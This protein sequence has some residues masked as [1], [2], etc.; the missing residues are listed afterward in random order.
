MR[1]C[2][3]AL[4]L[5]LQ[6]ACA[7]SPGP[8][9]LRGPYLQQATHAQVVVCWQS[10]AAGTGV[11]AWGT[12]PDRLDRM[13]V[14]DR[15]GTEHQIRLTGLPSGTRIHYAWGFEG[16]LRSDPSQYY[17]VA[18]PPGADVPVRFWVLGDSGTGGAA[19]QA[20]FAAMLR[21]APEVGFLV[22]VGDIAYERG[23]AAELSR[24]FFAIYAPLLRHTPVWPA[25]ANH[26]IPSNDVAAGTGAFFDAFVLPA[27]G[28]AG[29]EPSGTEAYYA[30]D[31]GP[32][33][34][35]V[36]DTAHDPLTPE[37]PMLA[38]LE[39]DLAA[40]E[41]RWT[42]A[43]FHHPPYSKGTHDSDREARMVRVREHVVP[44]LER[45]GV[46]LVLSGHSHGYERTALLAGAW[47]TPSVRGNH[48]LDD[49]P[50]YEKSPGPLGGTIYMVAGHGGADTGGSMDH[51]LVV[52]SST[53]HG[54]VLIEIEGEELR[55]RN[56]RADGRPGDSFT[57]VERR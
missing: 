38:W 24:H 27:E 55:G 49:E 9:P 53:A 39:R 57:L 56:V 12:E 4:A 37:S 29:G 17:D 44:I 25:I 21:E 3:A 32:A 28:E 2:L 15:H 26:D 7:G 16:A 20:V 22:H 41:A 13:V 11:V 40:S 30:F 52:A 14:G 33:H 5:V 36:L 45:H 46:D 34:V 10:E 35:V 8:V 23:S 43:V 50:P 31:W 42:I 51:P 19:Q 1:G 18:P 47:E 48:V 6:A 54:A